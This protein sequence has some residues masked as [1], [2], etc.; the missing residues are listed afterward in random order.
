MHTKIGD[1]ALLGDTQ[2]AALVSRDGSIDWMCLPR[3]DSPPCFAAMLGGS[4]HGHWLLAP[5]TAPPVRRRYRGDT[6]V[7]ET[8]YECPEGAVTVVDTMP[9]AVGG[10]VRVVRLVIGRGGQ[11]PMRM[12]LVP[13]FGY[14]L[15]TPALER[16]GPDLLAVCGLHA[17]RFATPAPVAVKN[18]SATASFTVSDQQRV[19]FMITWHPA[20]QPPP[21][22]AAPEDL[23][24]ACERWVARLGREVHV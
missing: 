1:Y 15:H 18:G 22:P 5:T 9:P 11:V 7:L 8:D 19:P 23:I 21:P 24:T 17:L 20:H 3:F 2:T 16:T 10:T 6:L 14:G 4:E 13:R 12:E